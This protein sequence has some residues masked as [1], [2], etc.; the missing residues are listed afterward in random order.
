MKQAKQDKR[1]QVQSKYIKLCWKVTKFQFK[2]KS[3]M[4]KPTKC[5]EREHLRTC[6]C[7][8]QGDHQT[9]WVSLFHCLWSFPL[10][11]VSINHVLL[12]SL[13]KW[14][15]G[16]VFFILIY[17][18]YAILSSTNLGFVI[19]LCLISSKRKASGHL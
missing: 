12:E 3:C 13:F 17:D 19:G 11:M 14:Q 1:K 4:E 8:H 6:K 15:L 2:L 5:F 10:F 9:T 7:L 18:Y 16:K